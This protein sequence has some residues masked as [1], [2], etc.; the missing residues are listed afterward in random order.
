VA[1]FFLKIVPVAAKKVA[2][3]PPELRVFVIYFHPPDEV[4]RRI[5]L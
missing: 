5:V 2:E 1:S 4:V 3:E